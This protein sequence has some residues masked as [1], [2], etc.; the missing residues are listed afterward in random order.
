M[1]RFR[2]KH[3]YDDEGKWIPG[4][5]NPVVEVMAAHASEAAEKVCNTALM[6]EGK[7]GKYRAQVWPVGGVRAPHEISHFYSP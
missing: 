2:V 5:P 1:R 7:L 6:A 4:H 3:D